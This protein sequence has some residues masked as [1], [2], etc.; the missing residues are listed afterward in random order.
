MRAMWTDFGLDYTASL[1]LLLLS[2]AQIFGFGL[3]L[4]DLNAALLI[5][6]P[7]C[8]AFSLRN[9]DRF[10]FSVDV[11]K[12]FVPNGRARAYY[13]LGTLRNGEQ[14]PSFVAV[15]G[16]THHVRGRTDR[17]NASEVK[18]AQKRGHPHAARMAVGSAYK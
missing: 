2:T 4:R 1:D 9:H 6:L 15:S 10:P 18:Y 14:V 8:L 7:A 16:A 5:A 11:L 17:K 3:E 12:L 13:H